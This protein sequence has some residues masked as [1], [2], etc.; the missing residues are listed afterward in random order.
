MSKPSNLNSIRMIS[1][2]LGISLGT[3]FK[4]GCGMYGENYF[5]R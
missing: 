2:K 4:D 5:G 3:V 1:Q